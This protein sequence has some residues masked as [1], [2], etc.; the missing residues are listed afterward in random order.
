MEKDWGV[1]MWLFDFI[2]SLLL[3]IAVYV[4]LFN[5]CEFKF[6]VTE[7][8][9][10]IIL[11]SI[12]F[13]ALLALNHMGDIVGFHIASLFL[14]L[15]YI[16][17]L[18]VLV[19]RKTK[20]KIFI[21]FYTFM[22]TIFFML[23]FPIA[24][25]VMEVF[26]PSLDNIP[27]WAWMSVSYLGNLIFIFALSRYV[28][29]KLRE[30]FV[31]LTLNMKLKFARNG[32]VFSLIIFILTLVNLFAQIIGSWVVIVLSNIVMVSI[33]YITAIIMMASSFYSQHKEAET[34]FKTKAQK[35]LE[36]HTRQLEHAYNNMRTFRHDYRNL[37]ATL[38]GYDN[39]PQLKEHLSKSLGYAEEALDN[40]DSVEG[41]LNLIN[42]VELKGLLWTKCAQAEAQGIKIELNIAEPVY[43][44]ALSREDLCRLVGIVTD[45]AIEEL[46]SHDYDPKTLKLSI[47]IDE[48][49]LIIDCANPC[50]VQPLIKKIFDEG[51]STKGPG[52]GL[53]LSNLKQICENNKNV[54]Y[55][56]RLTDG[57]FAIVILI[58]K[59]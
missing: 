20:H 3:F 33:I 43:D 12:C 55:T 45:N 53:G 6:S 10:A 24:S 48:G 51:Y 16:P 59:V 32:F 2:P 30:Y 1:V 47:I 58:R 25:S 19:S 50:K 9:V 14:Q 13:N 49:D 54:S 26:V 37:L 44:A 18:M 38:N 31:P 23:A 57:E 52:R 7:S 35:D 34:A 27:M 39:L 5:L 21:W 4:V 15:I 8:I 40:L 28:G 22:V 36:S 11:T 56:L 41:R 29:K 46:L 17:V 42:I